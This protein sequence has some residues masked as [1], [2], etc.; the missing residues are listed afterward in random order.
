MTVELSASVQETFTAK[1]A[2][3]EAAR[4]LVDLR[5][6]KNV[7][8][9]ADRLPPVLFDTWQD[10][11]TG[12]R[13]SKLGRNDLSLDVRPDHVFDSPDGSTPLAQRHG[14]GLEYRPAAGAL[15]GLSL[16]YGVPSTSRT[17]S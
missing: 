6:R 1:G 15:Y 11:C 5:L 8:T 16:S 2:L 10:A 17:R 3:E 12:S 4:H 9:G 13:Q 7:A 14:L